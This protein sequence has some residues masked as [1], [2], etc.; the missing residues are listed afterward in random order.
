M[1][2]PYLRVVFLPR[3]LC[4][5][6]FPVPVLFCCCGCEEIDLAGVFADLGSVPQSRRAVDL[7]GEPQ[8]RPPARDGGQLRG[9]T[10]NRPYCL[11]LPPWG[12][13]IYLSSTPVR[14]PTCSNM[15]M[16]RGQ[17]FDIAER[18]S[19]PSSRSRSVEGDAS[20]SPILYEPYG[21]MLAGWTRASCMAYSSDT[22][23]PGWICHLQIPHLM[24]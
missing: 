22:C 24:I 5:S 2:G 7:G 16:R 6:V 19:F 23:V 8:H 13:Y 12:R 1:D 11:L 9:E 15:K 18:S 14:S 4:C 17:C 20:I 10:N 21:P 3:C